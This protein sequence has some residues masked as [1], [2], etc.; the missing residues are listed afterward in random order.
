KATPS[1]APIMILTRTSDTYSPGAR[2]DFAST[3]L[4]Q[5]IAQSDGVGDVDG[6]G[7]SLPAVRVVL[8]PPALCTQGVSLDAVRAA[9]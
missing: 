2:Y 5:T 9:L 4:A 1:D 6:G 3:Q 8:H 7:S